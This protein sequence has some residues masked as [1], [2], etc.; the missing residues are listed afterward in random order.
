MASGA[1]IPLP[2]V[3]DGIVK[4]C[5]NP[6]GSSK[7]FKMNV[8]KPNVPVDLVYNVETAPLT[9]NN[10]EEPPTEDGDRDVGRIYRVL[11]KWHNATGTDSENEERQGVRVG[12]FSIELGYGVGD[13]PNSPN[14]FVAI[15]N[16]TSAT[17]GLEPAKPLGF[18]LR[19]CMA[20]HFFD[21]IRNPSS[22]GK[23]P[24]TVNQIQDS[25]GQDLRQEIWLQEEYSTFSPKMYSFPDDKRTIDIGGGFWDKQPAA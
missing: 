19:E 17:A 22:T 18:E 4:D 8:L 12:G 23:N 5:S 2:G 1:R 24:C 13:A 14:P 3:K 7:R 21:V 11:Q 9:Y 20:D 15:P 25:T 10:Y 6:Q 16:A